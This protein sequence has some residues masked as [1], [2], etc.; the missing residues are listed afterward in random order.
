MNRD[1]STSLR[2]ATN[3]R[4]RFEKGTTIVEL[5]VAI[6]I[7]AVISTAAFTMLN[8]QQNA[9]IGLNGQVALNMA[10]RNT[11][12]MMQIDLAN[13]ASY[14]YQNS[15]LNVGAL[16]V[17]MINHVVASGSSCYTAP[18]GSAILG[19]YGTN[20]FDQLNIIQ[21]DSTYPTVNATD[22]TGANGTGNCSNTNNGIA[23]GQAG[24]LPNGTALTLAQTAA[25]YKIGDQLFLMKNTGLAFT[26]VVLTAV[27]TVSG[28]A[29]KFVFN[30]TTTSNGV[31]G[32]NTLANDPL[33]ITACS[34]TTPCPPASVTGTNIYLTNSFCGGGGVGVV[35]GD[36]ILKL[37]PITYQVNSSATDYAGYQNPTLTRTQA[38]VTSNVMEQVIGFKVGGSI[39]NDPDSANTDVTNYNY[40]SSTYT[41]N[42]GTAGANAYN[43]TL[44]RSIRVSLIGRTAP[45]Y[46]KNYVFRNTFDGGPYQVQG[47]ATVV[48]PRNMNF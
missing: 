20:C 3:P 34:G 8:K 45:N 26:S 12:S 19:T 18:T 46:T 42:P 13:A 9:S 31:S 28:S 40:D 48:N 16:G 21:V 4:G 5:M 47:T 35:G 44:L 30:S 33:N 1:F 41:L 39:W 29:V 7:F 43:F 37:A 15:G 36:W 6:A 32:V 25:S 23:Y 27:P 11:V 2:A 22:S 38:G 17:T 24:V 10:L 14:Y